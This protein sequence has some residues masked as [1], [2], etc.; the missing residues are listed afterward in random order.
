M[1]AEFY[2]IAPADADAASLSAT[3]AAALATPGVAALLLP[4]GER[5]ENAYKS[6]VKAVAPAAQAAGVAVLVEGEPGLVR[7][8]GVDGLH[9]S[10]G[11]GA[12]REAVAA[13]KP[14]LIVGVGD[15]RTRHDAMQKGE[16]DIDYIL[17]G[18]LSGSIG[19][20]GREL[21]RW[22]AQTM[23]VPSVLCDPDTGAPEASEGCEFVGLSLARLEQG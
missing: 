1:S 21:A 11:I 14:D 7:L 3:L 2:L 4:R 19:E 23:E 5:S 10:G 16:L 15:V 9:V 22:W 6:F 13:L 17:F 12:V 8:L 18:P 20:Q